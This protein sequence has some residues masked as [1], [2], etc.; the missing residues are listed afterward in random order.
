ATMGAPAVALVG[1]PEDVAEGILD[2]KHAG[3]SQFLFIGWPDL[4]QM[5][6]FHRDVLPLVRE[7]ECRDEREQRKGGTA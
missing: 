6:T 1:S 5:T 4:E 2:L 3:V 7:L